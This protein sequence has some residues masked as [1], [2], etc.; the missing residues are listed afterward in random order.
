MGLVL[1][2]RRVSKKVDGYPTGGWLAQRGQRGPSV[3]QIQGQDTALHPLLEAQAMGSR[4]SG[5]CQSFTGAAEIGQ[6]GDS[7]LWSQACLT[8][9]SEGDSG[10]HSKKLC[11]WASITNST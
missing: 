4:F 8:Q 5:P 2:E 1:W 3:R 11:E 10:S 9:Q 7:N 6:T